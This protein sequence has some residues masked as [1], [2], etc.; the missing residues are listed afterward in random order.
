MARFFTTS[1]AGD[2]ALLEGEDTRHIAKSLRMRVGEELTLCDSAGTDYTCI[3]TAIQDSQVA[4][5]VCGRIP[6]RSEMPVKIRLYQAVPKGEK[7]DWI[8]QKAV[9]LGVAEV[10]PVLTARC[11]SRPDSKTAAKKQDRLARIA[12]EAAKQSGRGIVPQVAAQLPFE[13]ALRQAAQSGRVLLFYERAQRPLREHLTAFSGDSLDIFV[14]SE[15]GF[16]PEEVELA[17]AHGAKIASLGPRILRCETAA[18]CALSAV[19]Y[20]LGEF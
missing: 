7:M 2:T 19:S 5:Q 10:I 9:E 1:I 14:G 12:L 6:T 18:L 4:L 20:A 3:I 17:Q 8:V 16:A 11:V 13:A 15:G